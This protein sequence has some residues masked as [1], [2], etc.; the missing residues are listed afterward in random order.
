MFAE[1]SSFSDTL[2]RVVLAFVSHRR[3]MVEGE[4]VRVSVPMLPNSEL[5]LQSILRRS[6]SCDSEVSVSSKQDVDHPPYTP[7]PTVNWP[8]GMKA[9]PLY[10]PTVLTARSNMATRCRYAGLPPPS[11]T[12]AH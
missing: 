10:V 12:S 7:Q 9:R 11:S 5:R 3:D 2:R 4:E 8:E 6:R 1:V